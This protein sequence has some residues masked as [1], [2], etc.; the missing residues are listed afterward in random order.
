MNRCNI[1]RCIA[2]IGLLSM[3]GM[4]AN[5]S[6]FRVCRV[7]HSGQNTVAAIGAAP[8]AGQVPQP[9]AEVSEEKSQ[10]ESGDAHKRASDR[11]TAGNQT[12]LKKNQAP[13]KKEPV[14]SVTDQAQGGDPVGEADQDQQQT[15]ELI[16][17]Y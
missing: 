9:P 11:D 16:R 8:F 3:L 10:S 7:A 13:I 5:A 12:N 17:G 1:K 6:D 4:S 2:I 14:D 15:E